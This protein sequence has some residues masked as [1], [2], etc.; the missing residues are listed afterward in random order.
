LKPFAVEAK[1]PAH[2]KSLGENARRVRKQL[3]TRLRDGAMYGLGVFA[4]DRMLGLTDGDLVVAH[5][6]A[7]RGILHERVGKLVQKLQSPKFRLA[8]TADLGAI[9]TSG[10]VFCREPGFLVTI[11][12]LAFFFTRPEG[13]PVSDELFAALRSTVHQEHRIGPF[14][15]R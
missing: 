11:S 6:D 10:A 12:E 14:P 4:S 9:L 15:T 13:H 8:E 7:L 5:E 1:R 2:I 3:K